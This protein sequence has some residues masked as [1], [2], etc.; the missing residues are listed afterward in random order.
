M[1][2]SLLNLPEDT[3]ADFAACRLALPLRWAVPPAKFVRTAEFLP[4][5]SRWQL[6]PVCAKPKLRSLIRDSTRLATL[7]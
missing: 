3:Q 5:P 4:W 6:A 2:G 1:H 7:R